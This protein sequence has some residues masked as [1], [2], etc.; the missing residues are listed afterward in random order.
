MRVRLSL[1]L[2]VARNFSIRLSIYP[3]NYIYLLIGC[4]LI[5]KCLIS[6]KSLISAVTSHSLVNRLSFS[7]FSSLI[8]VFIFGCHLISH[9]NTLILSRASLLDGATARPSLCWMKVSFTKR[10]MDMSLSFKLIYM[11][12]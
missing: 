4:Y 6:H 10:V 1:F 8:P 9:P 5:T 7:I 3:Y 11:C 2:L 12:S